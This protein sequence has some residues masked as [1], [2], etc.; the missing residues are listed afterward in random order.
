MSAFFQKTGQKATPLLK[1]AGNE[2]M[3]DRTV[4]GVDKNPL[5]FFAH[6]QKCWRD[7]PDRQRDF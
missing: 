6:F 7:S 2:K 4:N 1:P 5:R 3:S